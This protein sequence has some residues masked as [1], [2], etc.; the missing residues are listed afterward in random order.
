[1]PSLSRPIEFSMPP[2]VSTVRGG[3]L[4]IRGLGVIV[5]GRMAPKRPKSTNRAISRAYPKVPEAT[6]IGLASRR[7]PSWTSRQT[8]TE[9]TA[10]GNPG[11][12][13][14]QGERARE[15]ASG[16]KGTGTFFGG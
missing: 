5:F 2:V 9:L 6:A 4:P 16:R 14:E 12:A 15:D 7:R 11:L 10:E 8:S 13:A 1:M 3:G